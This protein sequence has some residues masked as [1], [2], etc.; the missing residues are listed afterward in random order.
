MKSSHFFESTKPGANDSKKFKKNAGE[1]LVSDIE[2][3]GNQK[4]NKG[5]NESFHGLGS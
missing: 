2:K 1:I 3:Q 5:N 4:A